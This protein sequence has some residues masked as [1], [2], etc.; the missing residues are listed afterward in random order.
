MPKI[1]TNDITTYYEI[2]GRGKPVVLIHRASANHEMWQPQVEYFSKKYKVL[3]YDVRGHGQSEGSDKYS[4]ELFADDLKA[5]LDNLNI[6]KPYVCG[7][8][9]GGMIAQAYAVKYSDALSALVLADTAASSALTLK[10]KLQKLLFPKFIVKF[11]IRILSMERY[12]DFAFLFFKK[13]KPDVKEYL[14][15]QL[16]DFKKQELLKLTDAIYDFNLLELSKINVPTLIVLGE[17]ERK[18]VFIHVEKM[19]ELIKDSLI[20][21]I[22]DAMHTSNLEN[23]KKFN[24]ALEEFL[25]KVEQN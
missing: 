24:E 9:L 6:K 22:P 10:D 16:I 1:R 2:H 25:L 21:V 13:M 23:P 18:A 19:K 8:S 14:K 4:C 3:T 11:L 7:L 17:L 20:V 12:A 15:K 5:L